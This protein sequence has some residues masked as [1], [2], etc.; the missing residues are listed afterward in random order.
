[1]GDGMSTNL[2]ISV[3]G[4]GSMGHGIAQVSAV[5]GHDVV[6]RDIEDDLVESGLSA[7]EQ[8][9]EEGVDRGKVTDDEMAEAV[10]RLSGT[11]S[12]ETAVSGADLVIEAIPEQMDLK[13]DSFESVD[14]YAPEDAVLAT[15]TSSLSV[16]DIA[17]VLDDPGRMLGLHF[18]KPAHI[19]PI[20]EIVVAEQTRDDT[21]AFGETYVESTG[22]SAVEVKD[23]PGF[24]SSR[25]GAILSLEAIHMLQSGVASASD[26]DEAM[27]LGYNHTMGPIETADHTGLDVNLEV[28]EYLREELGERY[29]PPQI[30]KQ[31]VRAGKLGRKTGEGFYE[32]EDGEIVG[33]SD[34]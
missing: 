20:V 15:N 5:A 3:L 14:E 31:K 1:M 27:R 23:F 7:I 25:L 34:N 29:R 24:A 19:M 33:E 26:I 21:L 13:V 11:T 28:M 22:K 10:A 30:L 2:E 8:N 9:L 4:A 18:F 17:S 6:M 16:T 32:W 12:I